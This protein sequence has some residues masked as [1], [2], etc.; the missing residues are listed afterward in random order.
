MIFVS[1]FSLQNFDI[2]S[3]LYFFDAKIPG[4]SGRFREVR[5]FLS[6][7]FF[8]KKHWGFYTFGPRFPGGSGKFREV[9]KMDKKC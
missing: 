9:K 3:F 1:F 5:R 2:L 4:G 6:Q 8:E 7:E